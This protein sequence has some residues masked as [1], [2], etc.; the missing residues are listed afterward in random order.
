MSYNLLTA[1]GSQSP[2]PARQAFHKEGT[3]ILALTQTHRLLS[4][5]FTVRKSVPPGKNKTDASVR[6]KHCPHVGR[7]AGYFT[8]KCMNR[9]KLCFYYL[10]VMSRAD[11][12]GICRPA[13]A[14][15][16]TVTLIAQKKTLLTSDKSL[17]TQETMTEK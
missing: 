1:E 2:D 13:F 3:L 10:D 12:Q 9:C 14:Q 17:T 16:K 5:E 11:L 15:I 6:S 4:S 8:C 7:A